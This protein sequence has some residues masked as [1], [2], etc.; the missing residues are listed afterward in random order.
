MNG[1][2]AVADFLRFARLA[3]AAI[4]DRSHQGGASDSVVV[5]APGTIRLINSRFALN[6][7]DVR[8]FVTS[9]AG[10]RQIR[11]A[12]DA[13]VVLQRLAQACSSRIATSL[14]LASTPCA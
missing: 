9:P 1:S 13:E 2:L 4:T 5:P 10:S 7:E 11:S 6:L 14:R 8:G 12:R 3:I